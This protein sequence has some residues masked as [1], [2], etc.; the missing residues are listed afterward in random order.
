MTSL[1]SSGVLAAF[2]EFMQNSEGTW[3]LL[4]ILLICLLS[5]FWSALTRRFSEV[6]TS[7][8][9][10]VD[11]SMASIALSVE[12]NLR[13]ARADAIAEVRTVTAEARATM[14]TM[15]ARIEEQVLRGRQVV[16]ARVDAVH[17]QAQSLVR[18]VRGAIQPYIPGIVQD[19]NDA[20][21]MLKK[22]LTPET[23]L[24]LAAILMG[25]LWTTRRT[26]DKLEAR[27]TKLKFSEGN[28][29]SL[30]WVGVM[31][32]RFYHRG[33][34]RLQAAASVLAKVA[35]E[36]MTTVKALFSVR[37]AVDGVGNLC[38][39]IFSLFGDTL[40]GAGDDE[41]KAAVEE[42]VKAAV[43]QADVLSEDD[44]VN[45]PGDEAPAVAVGPGLP[46][47]W[48]EMNFVRGGVMADVD[49]LPPRS[50]GDCA[51][52]LPKSPQTPP[53]SGKR[54]AHMESLRVAWEGIEEKAKQFEIVD[55]EEAVRRI[56]D[57]A[58]RDPYLSGKVKEE[59]VQSR[60]K[61]LS[62]GPQLGH[63]MCNLGLEG[64]AMLFVSTS[65]KVDDQFYLTAHV[66]DYDWHSGCVCNDA[67]THVHLRCSRCAKPQ[68]VGE[69]I[70]RVQTEEMMKSHKCNVLLP[71]A[72]TWKTAVSK[73]PKLLAP[74]FMVM[75]VVW[76]FSR[77]KKSQPCTVCGKVHA[78]GE[79]C[80]MVQRLRE[81]NDKGPDALEG[82]GMLTRHRAKAAGRVAKDDS[83][84]GKSAPSRPRGHDIGHDELKMYSY[85]DPVLK[86]KILW[87]TS[88]SSDADLSEAKTYMND[89]ETKQLVKV[90]VADAG[91]YIV[92]ELLSLE[93]LIWA[94]RRETIPPQASRTAEMVAHLSKW[95]HQWAFLDPNVEPKALGEMRNLMK[96]AIA[97][98]RLRRNDAL[99][100]WLEEHATDKSNLDVKRNKQGVSE[101]Q[102]TAVGGGGGP[103]VFTVR[104][105][106]LD[107]TEA[108]LS[109]TKL[110]DEEMATAIRLSYDGYDVMTAE[111]M[112]S[113]DKH[114]LQ[115]VKS[116]LRDRAA[117][118]PQIDEV[119]S[120]VG[121][122]DAQPDEFHDKL[123]ALVKS[124]MEKQKLQQ[125]LESRIPGTAKFRL[126]PEQNCMRLLDENRKHLQFVIYM[127]GKLISQHHSVKGGAKYIRSGT[128]EI[129]VGSLDWIP[130][131]S[132]PEMLMARPPKEITMSSAF[133]YA[134]PKM[135]E[136]VMLCSYDDLDRPNPWRTGTPTLVGSVVPGWDCDGKLP[137]KITVQQALNSTEK[138]ECGL[139]LTNAAGRVVGFHVG[140]HG[141]LNA[142]V[143][144]TEAM[145]AE[146]KSDIFKPKPNIGA[147]KSSVENRKGLTPDDEEWVCKKCDQSKPGH[148][149]NKC[150][151]DP[152][153]NSQ[154]G[155]A[156]VKRAAKKEVKPRL[157]AADAPSE[158]K[159]TPV[160]K[161]DAKV[162]RKN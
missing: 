120:L 154:R 34:L 39:D 25:Y 153:R 87:W 42:L 47:S 57:F 43:E 46:G 12:T 78:R 129:P 22:L 13:A 95:A 84:V 60:L 41:K 128:W 69:A 6:R 32:M 110:T 33:D 138:G 121:A 162:K 152:N 137:H 54:A 130:F 131:E 125:A 155:G 75:F 18:D 15:Q 35:G 74:A 122:V 102:F 93:R 119:D 149:P 80:P 26:R 134:V 160:R 133:D 157:E 101:I 108:R 37:D 16:E 14:Q 82:R 52:P 61:V 51:V 7:L 5:A 159:K 103:K 99:Q 17:N 62:R 45:I 124:L 141:T 148:Y 8:K 112:L 2:A 150:P 20:E 127:N 147:G 105:R 73:I 106:P 1:G 53:D 28:A 91:K 132:C 89:P 9:E 81:G 123:A 161:D 126:F 36:S 56:R 104:V 63:W 72:E 48:H 79:V 40:Q 70:T 144:I 44:V 4:C 109:E 111:E 142:F 85:V 19:G 21:G 117:K 31:M 23:V 71:Q 24:P 86:R 88:G 156:T 66:S 76:I 145:I 83:D 100:D 59:I 136:Q 146:L 50:T 3:M 77:K 64:C 94:M 151:T 97:K 158:E 135:S 116:Q 68:I 143:P 27:G 107:E 30:M 114:E 58:S 115:H 65:L 55:T 139:P 96:G 67:E 90:R 29:T 113:H 140:T 92:G 38:E 49:P 98:A 10:M 11:H 118:L